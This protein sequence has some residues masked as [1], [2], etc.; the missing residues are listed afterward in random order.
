[1]SRQ[2]KA[3][4][5]VLS[6]PQNDHRELQRGLVFCY[7]SQIVIH[8]NFFIHSHGRVRNSIEYTRLSDLRETP[9]VIVRYFARLLRFILVS[10]CSFGALP[11]YN[12]TKSRPV[13][14]TAADR[15]SV[16]LTVSATFVTVSK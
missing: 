1:M 14:A 15:S 2:E 9:P 3:K 5:S 10:F 11:R 6:S 13:H 7:E 8:Y 12:V 4:I 16:R